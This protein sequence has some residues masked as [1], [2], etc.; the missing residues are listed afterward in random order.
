M[1]Q[2]PGNMFDVMY[3]DSR[4]NGHLQKNVLYKS[5]CW[6][7]MKSLQIPDIVYETNKFL[8]CWRAQ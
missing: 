6:V 1:M 3:R 5:I 2:Y 4:K 7:W 8:E